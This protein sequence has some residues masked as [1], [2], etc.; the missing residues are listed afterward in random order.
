MSRHQS[1]TFF[2]HVTFRNFNHR[3]VV[4]KQR[5]FLACIFLIAVLIACNKDSD[6]SIPET[7]SNINVFMAV[8][9]LVADVVLD[10]TTIATGMEMGESTGYHSFLAKRYDL[11]I[12]ES[13]NRT[14]PIVSGQISLRNNHHYS[15]YLSLDHNRAL[16]VLAVED[17]LS[18]PPQGYS[19]VRLIDLSDTYN[20]NAENV[21]LDFQVNTKDTIRFRNIGYLAVTAFSQIPFNTYTRNIYSANTSTSFLGNISPNVTFEDRKIYSWIVYGNAQVADSFKLVEFKHN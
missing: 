8:P 14:S 6:S 19:K 13:G 4:M 5:I 17:D 7:S 3:H 2:L 11:A 12:F 16:R 21:L 18:L 20:S 10:T 1:G 15:V 9:G